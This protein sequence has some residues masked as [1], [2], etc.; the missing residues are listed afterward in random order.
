SVVVVVVVRPALLAR[1][2]SKP[3]AITQGFC[4]GIASTTTYADAAAMGPPSGRRRWYCK[5]QIFC[6]LQGW[7]AVEGIYCADFERG[8]EADAEM[9]LRKAT[10]SPIP[11]GRVTRTFYGEGEPLECVSKIGLV[12]EPPRGRISGPV[13]ISWRRT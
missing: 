4:V 12:S 9:S 11:L 2:N 10:P 7:A 3:L 13:A 5:M 8:P 6:R 1:Y